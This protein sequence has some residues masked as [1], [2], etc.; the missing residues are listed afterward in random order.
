MTGVE[1]DADARLLICVAQRLVKVA[2]GHPVPVRL[3]PGKRLPIVIVV[4]VITVEL[5]VSVVIIESGVDV[6]NL[7]VVHEGAAV[8]INNI[9][10]LAR[11]GVPRLA[12]LVPVAATVLVLIDRVVAAVGVKTGSCQIGNLLPIRKLTKLGGIRQPNVG[13][14]LEAAEDDLPAHGRLGGV[15][16]IAFRFHGAVDIDVRAVVLLRSGAE[17]DIAIVCVGKAIVSHVVVISVITVILI[18]LQVAFPDQL[19]SG[20]SSVK[21]DVHAVGKTPVGI[22][23]IAPIPIAVYGVFDKGKG[24]CSRDVGRSAVVTVEIGIFIAEGLTAVLKPDIGAGSSGDG[25]GHRRA[26]CH[27]TQFNGINRLQ[28]AVIV[29]LKEDRLDIGEIFA[30]LVV[31]SH[32][33][34]GIVLMD[35]IV[36]KICYPTAVDA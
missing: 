21:I 33:L 30:A 8:D 6:E 29:R 15:D 20:Q 14:D 7:I 35:R 24:L 28:C 31:K 23:R 5:V 13:I 17:I 19:Q 16:I 27:G 36:V 9:S 1:G 12:K 32:G 2:E 18:V 26:V 34:A 3:K 4:L 10:I 25:K 22:R 11:G